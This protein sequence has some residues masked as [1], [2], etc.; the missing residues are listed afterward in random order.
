MKSTLDW[1]RGLTVSWPL[2]A[3]LL[4]TGCGGDETGERAGAKA[5]PPEN[6]TAILE[7]Y[8][9][10]AEILTLSDAGAAAGASEAFAAVLEASNGASAAFWEDQ[11][12]ILLERAQVMAGQDDVEDQRYEFES[13][14]EAMI[15][16]AERYGSPGMAIYV[17]RCPMVRGGSADWL[18]RESGIRNPYHGDRMM[19]CGMT[20]REIR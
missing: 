5:E 16:V 17:Q 14:S 8:F 12:A 13:L 18:S 11:R 4:L 15:R 2:I 9:D 6:Y 1:F 3:V 7:S 19:T 10:L 20:L